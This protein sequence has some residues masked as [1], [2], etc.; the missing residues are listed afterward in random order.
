MARPSGHTNSLHR[1]LRGPA[2]LVLLFLSAALAL[3]AKGSSAS[4]PAAF[5]YVPVAPSHFAIADLDGD[6][7]PDLATVEMAQVGVS[8]A[9]YWIG[10]QMSAGAKQRIGLTGPLGGLEIAS[11][12]VNGDHSLDL[13]VTTTWF[14]N[15]VAVLLNDGHGNFTL[16][17]AAGFSAAA[18]SSERIW[19]RPNVDA[20]DAA[21]AV[22]A[23][24]SS[25]CALREGIAPCSVH[26]E[27][28][29]VATSDHHIFT[30]AVSA[31]GRAP[32]TLAVHV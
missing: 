27:I 18:L 17:D 14:K 25:D 6:N 20:K 7:R 19:A 23:R 29:G 11:R 22:L 5:G 30:L 26:P 9:R 3:E 12:D 21:L 28:A 15:P 24:S 8:Q 31:L 32:P 10:F 16:A 13:I 4:L 1:S 2:C